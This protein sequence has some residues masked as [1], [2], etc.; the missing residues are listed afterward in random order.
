MIESKFASEQIDRLSGLSF[1]PKPVKGDTAAQAAYKELRLALECAATDAIGKL[2]VD[3]WLKNSADAPKPAQLRKAAYDENERLELEEASKYRPP[4]PRQA[5]CY[6]CQDF[7]IAENV[8]AGDIRSVASYCDCTKGRERRAWP[9][10][11]YSPERVNAARRKLI[12]A[13]VIPTEGAAMR[14]VADVYRGEF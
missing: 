13:R 3:D 2:V 12:A 7:G 5:H 11:A 6:Q 8:D 10:D 9:N 1:F 4:A 14:H